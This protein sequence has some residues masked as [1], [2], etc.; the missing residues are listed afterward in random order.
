MACKIN[1]MRQRAIE[2]RKALDAA[3]DEHA[4]NRA[5]YAALLE[6]QAAGTV[7]ADDA[8]LG[9]LAEAV[10]RGE[11][12]LSVKRK[13]LTSAEEEVAAEEARLA[14]EDAG[15][16][17]RARETG[18]DGLGRPYAET[19]GGGAA[20]AGGDSD[21]QP[22]TSPLPAL[23]TRTLRALQRLY[24]NHA[25]TAES[26]QRFRAIAAGVLGGVIPDIRAASEAGEYSAPDGGLAVSPDVAS[27]IFVRAGEQSLWMRLGARVERMTS[28]ERLITALDDDDETADALASIVAED[29]PESVAGTVQWA[30][31]RQVRLVADKLMVLAR[32]TN[33]LGEDAPDY[34]SALEDAM[35]RAIS[36]RIDRIMLNG[37]NG[38]GGLLGAPSTI[39]VSPE[40][41]QVAD[42]I[43]WKNAIK[44]WAR[45]APGSHENSVWIVHPT[46]LPQLLSMFIEM[47]SSGA[48]PRGVF[49]T[50]GP[51]G[52]TML[53]RPVYVTSRVKKLGDLGDIMLVDPTQ[54]VIGIR[55][56]IGVDRSPFPYFTSDML[57]LR[58]RWRGCAGSLWDAPVTPPEGDT[59][60]P[61]VVLGAR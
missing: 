46:T 3:M 28:H 25:Y 16:E 18:F 39:T 47:G 44:M 51:T 40:G 13:R 36:R 50:G 42:T 32:V 15:L 26:K 33:E 61:C 45:L 35:I 41:S 49:E 7:K 53:T 60:S 43:V 14:A 29:T 19:Y 52:Y 5:T 22:A 9:Q 10:A 23:P 6:R 27:G 37:N 56:G 8:R 4:E 59:L 1:E 55:T 38:A 54:T 58:A 20:R 21:D 34:L 30:K 11:E 12:R 24:G 17:R 2:S 31:V 57:A 48:Q